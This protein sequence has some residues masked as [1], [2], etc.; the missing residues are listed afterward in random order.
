L[1]SPSIRAPRIPDSVSTFL[2]RAVLFGFVI[3]LL[4]LASQGA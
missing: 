3:F 1:S 4:A 2:A